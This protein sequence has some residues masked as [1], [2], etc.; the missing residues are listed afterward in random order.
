MKS[1]NTKNAI[2]IN[3][4]EERNEN[5]IIDTDWNNE[6]PKTPKISMSENDMRFAIHDWRRFGVVH[7]F[8]CTLSNIITLGVYGVLQEKI[9]TIPYE[10]R[11]SDKYPDAVFTSSIFLVFSN[12]IWSLCI[13]FIALMY[14]KQARD[15]FWARKWC[16]PQAELKN[17]AFVA[18]SNTVST[19]CQYEVL[20]Y[21]SY[22]ISTLAKAT[23]ILPTMVWGIFLHGRRFSNSQYLSAV[24]VT[25]G[26]FVFVYNSSLA[27]KN[28]VIFKN[29]EDGVIDDVD[30]D[31]NLSSK[32]FKL[33]ITDNTDDVY[34]KVVAEDAIWKEVGEISAFQQT[35]AWFRHIAKNSLAIGALIMLIYS[36]AD[37]FTSS[38]QQR[39]FRVQKISLF[40]QMFWTCVFGTFFSA[41]WV[42]FS[43][44]LK[45]AMFFLKRYPDINP[46]I[47][48]LSIASALSQIS[49]TYTIR[50]FGAVTLAT[51]LTIRQVFSI[52]L[53][54][55]LFH[56]PLAGSQ[57][58]GL[59]LILLPLFLGISNA[60]VVGLLE[61]PATAISLQSVFKNGAQV[62]EQG[63]NNNNNN[64]NN[65]NNNNCVIE[66][67]EDDV[68]YENIRG[69]GV[70][71]DHGNDN[72]VISISS[73]K[74]YVI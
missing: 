61:T 34:S 30:D 67:G 17:Y 37:G 19:L 29:Y 72:I 70:L 48:Y 33:I 51:V 25:A 16:F 55:F 52:S 35:I 18:F 14:T 15:S 54:A 50:A 9:M 5:N 64:D 1:L 53:N 20:K 24:F 41:M 57:W 11:E 28:R 59:V 26:C 62:K 58:I 27:A 21:L 13:S 22:A 45:Y 42:I 46:D 23:K 74:N 7:L 43:G 8:A 3:M 40:D 71:I 36:T 68:I 32:A 2:I 66:D 60:D 39:M 38:F 63:V 10:S 65:N 56:E 73:R 44:Q 69:N 31:E 6:P 4:I 49:I 12:R 47:F